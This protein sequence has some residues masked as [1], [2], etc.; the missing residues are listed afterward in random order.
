LSIPAWHTFEGLGMRCNRLVRWMGVSALCLSV[1]VAGAA[2]TVLTQSATV[3]NNS[4]QTLTFTFSFSHAFVGL[5]HYDVKLSMAG[6]FAD[7]ARNGATVAA[8]APSGHLT[9]FSF[10][11]GQGSLAL[12]GVGAAASLA[13][14][15]GTA[16]E[17]RLTGLS[18]K[19]ADAPSTLHFT[20]GSPTPNVG[21]VL[22]QGAVAGASADGGTDGVTIGPAPGDGLASFGFTRDGGTDDLFDV[23]DSDAS[24][25]P[26]GGVQASGS[27]F[28]DCATAPACVAQQSVLNLQ[29]GGGDDVA[30][31]VLRH[32]FG[33]DPIADTDSVIDLIDE[34]ITMTSFSCADAGGCSSLTGVMSFSLTPGDVLA[35]V[36]RAEINDAATV[37][38]PG[39]LLAVLAASTAAG[40]ARRRPRQR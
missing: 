13:G 11:T 33:G 25:G 34:Q 27:E 8:L 35:F 1:G 3:L 16:G 18:F 32:E 21:R 15:G 2:P 40:L 7:G 26:H 39:G 5:G 6:S 17:V 12:G 38:E 4:N 23:N 24:P 20:S 28:F 36:I 14:T 31:F 37:P 22:S 19:D 29:M 9:E 30:A 10:L